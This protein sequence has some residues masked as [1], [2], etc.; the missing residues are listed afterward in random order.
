MAPSPDALSAD[1]SVVLFS[2]PAP[3]VADDVDEEECESEAECQYYDNLT[4]A[5]VW[6]AGTGEVTMASRSG[7]CWSRRM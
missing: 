4:D 6:D 3:L 1:G 2:S 7:I 5:Y